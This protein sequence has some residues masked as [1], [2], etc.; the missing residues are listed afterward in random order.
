MDL[1]TEIFGEG[2]DLNTVQMIARGIV[3]FII[4]LILIRISGRRSF[5]VKT[6]MDNIIVILLGAMLSRAVVGASPFA[7][8]VATSCVI[9][10]LHRGLGWLSI[11]NPRLKKLIDGSKIKL[12]DNGQFLEENMKRAIICKDDILQSVRKSALTNDLNKIEMIHMESTGE[13]S[14]VKKQ[15]E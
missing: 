8:I 1:L 12:Y 6:P 13:I 11:R 15:G 10:L 7:P 4:T 14:T 9:V 2:K 3:V 5:G